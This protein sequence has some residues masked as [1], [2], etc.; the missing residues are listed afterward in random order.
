[1]RGQQRQHLHHNLGVGAV[2]HPVLHLQQVLIWPGEGRRQAVGSERCEE[3]SADWPGQ[4]PHRALARCALP[5]Q[6]RKRPTA[7]AALLTMR[8]MPRRRSPSSR[9]SIAASGVSTLAG[10]DPVHAVMACR[11]AE[12]VCGQ[13]R[14][15]LA[16]KAD[17]KRQRRH[18]H[19]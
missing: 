16:S 3:G 1:M 2:I 13:V 5:L 14:P 8:C 17:D 10:G 15:G 19:A 12:K 4:L 11:R 18:R 9:I 6:L 7:T